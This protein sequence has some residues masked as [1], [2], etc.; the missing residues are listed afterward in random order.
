M[1]FLFLVIIGD[2]N[3]IIP[4]MAI[5]AI[6]AIIRYVKVYIQVARVPRIIH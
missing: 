2:D 1:F 5:M 6:M 3:G 4:I